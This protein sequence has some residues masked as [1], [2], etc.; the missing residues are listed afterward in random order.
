MLK[1]EQV[2][3]Q[4]LKQ[5]VLA[6]QWG[7]VVSNTGSL[8]HERT[9]RQQ[10]EMCIGH[11]D[12]NKYTLRCKQKADCLQQRDE[13]GFSDDETEDCQLYDSLDAAS[14]NH[15]KCTP[16]PL[17]TEY[18]DTSQLLTDDAYYDL[19]YDPNWRT[20]L[21]G[22]GRFNKS[23]HISV[24]EYYQFP[25][26]KAAHPPVES[27]EPVTKG[28]YKYIVATS[29]AV[30]VTPDMAGNEPDQPY[31]LH[32][33]DVETSTP[34]SPHF[35]HHALQFRSAVVDLSKPPCNNPKEERDK[36]LL[37]G[38]KCKTFFQ[39][40]PRCPQGR[41]TA[42]EQMTAF[43]KDLFN[44]KPERLSGEI[45]ERNKTTLGHNTSKRGSYASV[46]VRKQDVN[47]SPGTRIRERKKAQQKEHPKPLLPQQQP[48]AEW[49]DCQSST[50][51]GASAV[52]KPNPQ[53]A[54]SLQPLL[55]TIHLN[56]SL[57]TASYFL[58]SIGDP[59]GLIDLAS[60]HSCPHW[61]PA[62]EDEIASSPGCQQINP[63]ISSWMSWRR[64]N[65]PH[66]DQD[67]CSEQRQRGAALQW[68]ITCE[69]EDQKEIAQNL[70]LSLGSSSYPLLPAIGKSMTG[71]E[72]E[73]SPDVNSAY[74]VHRSSSKGYLVKMEK[75]KQLRTRV[76]YKAYSLKDY[77]QLK[78]DIVLQGLGPDYTAIEET[79]LK[80]QKLY[81]NVIREQNKKIS[82]IPFLLAKDPEGN[83]NK[84]PRLKALEYAKTIAKPPLQF[85]PRQRQKPV[86]SKGFPEHASDMDVPHM[87]V[88]EVLRKRH[89]EEK[90]AV[91]LF[92]KQ[93]AV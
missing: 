10:L 41:L 24:E 88:L 81:S 58:P 60:L 71:K 87:A 72:P 54:I 92:R 5:A 34:T 28:G 63:G 42:T 64:V 17:Q 11:H 31:R 4:S 62:S 52:T 53:K 76:P 25:K 1:N 51:A 75:Q 13:D 12:Q 55:P 40:E 37:T 32:P 18:A 85:P 74:P 48:P 61:S 27:R 26:E 3:R 83:D 73:Q 69:G 68:P 29:P 50:L 43:P 33:Q 39:Q 21:R 38:D 79:K 84:V 35:H 90:Q 57:N 19:R 46:H 45:V 82:R 86:Q 36:S 9:S 93:H 70:T 23:P 91:S 59:D 16:T 47:K 7:S 66:R 20:N 89:E 22:A 77:K 6:N 80:R 56:V 49:G 30:L 8:A 2:K 78:S 67:S 14:H 44:K 65:L 15:A